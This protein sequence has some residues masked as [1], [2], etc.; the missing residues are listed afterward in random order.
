MRNLES[1]KY[2]Y[3]HR[4][5]FR[6]LVEKLIKDYDLKCELRTRAKVH[7]MDK[8]CEYLILPKDV[9]S[10]NHRLR[11][12]H[13]IESGMDNKTDIDLF[14]MIID[15]ESAGYTKPDKPL[16]AYDFANILLKDGK[17]NSAQYMRLLNIMHYLGIDNSHI[18][19]DDK[20]GMI[21]VNT[22]QPTEEDIEKAIQEYKNNAGQY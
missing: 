3:R 5:A 18:V 11:S 21:L 12:S 7:D 10:H 15:F 6:Y 13:H 8:M 19:T 4:V 17:I 20:I 14:E 9:A 22:C 16:C 1:C 2:T